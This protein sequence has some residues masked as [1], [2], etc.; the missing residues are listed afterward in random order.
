MNARASVGLHPT[1]R[2]VR[3]MRR[4]PHRPSVAPILSCCGSDQKRR[5]SDEEYD[6]ET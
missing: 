2:F 4:R 1:I 5:R 3:D 6:R